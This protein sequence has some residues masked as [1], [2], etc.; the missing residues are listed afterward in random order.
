MHSNV[1]SSI[2]SLII[3]I[4]VLIIIVYNSG[5]YNKLRSYYLTSCIA[6]FHTKF[7][8]YTIENLK[9]F[10]KNYTRNKIRVQY[11]DAELTQQ[12][13]PQFSYSHVFNSQC[14][15]LETFLQDSLQNYKNIFE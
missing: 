9:K 10:L 6:S 4:W 11:R 14:L 2:I 1:C 5:T 7:N 3:S 8:N 13:P 12:P 15:P